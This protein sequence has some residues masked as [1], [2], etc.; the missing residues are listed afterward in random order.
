MEYRKKYGSPRRVRDAQ[1]QA[2]ELLFRIG[3]TPHTAGFAMLRDGVRLLSDCDRNRHLKLTE[4]LYPA[5]AAIY[6][7]SNGSIEHAMR[8]AIRLAW[9]R[10]DKDRSSL[11]CEEQAP[12]NAALL[13]ALS[14][15]LRNGK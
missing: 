14:E 7:Q 8:D 15:H 13:Y 11:L 1:R 2:G 12:S 5:I 3:I 4:E 9:Q 10:E 6:L